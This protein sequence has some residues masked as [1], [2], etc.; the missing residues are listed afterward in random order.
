[1]SVQNPAFN[2]D[3]MVDMLR[4][5]DT[6]IEEITKGNF[7]I[8]K[9]VIADKTNNNKAMFDALEQ[10]IKTKKIFKRE[11]VDYDKWTEYDPNSNIILQSSVDYNAMKE[12]A[13]RNLEVD[14]ADVIWEKI[15]QKEGDK[16]LSVLISVVIGLVTGTGLYFAGGKSSTLE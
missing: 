2:T 10:N 12:A 8:S 5:F 14:L 7:I 4:A 16:M 13:I 6:G 3:S 15:P 9:K 1:M 11:K